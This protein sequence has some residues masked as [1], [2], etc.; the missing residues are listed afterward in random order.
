[1]IDDHLNIVFLAAFSLDAS[2][3]C[4]MQRGRSDFFLL[5]ILIKSFPQFAVLFE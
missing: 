1:M 2:F 4:V 3:L 5:A